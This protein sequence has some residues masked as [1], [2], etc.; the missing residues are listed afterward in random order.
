[1]DTYLAS[2]LGWKKERGAGRLKQ[3]ALFTINTKPR[4]THLANQYTFDQIRSHFEQLT[5][6]VR[7]A[8][9][10]RDSKLKDEFVGDGI[11]V[12]KVLG[13]SN[14]AFIIGHAGVVAGSSKMPWTPKGLNG[15]HQTLPMSLRY[16]MHGVRQV[17][18]EL[19]LE[20]GDYL[21][22]GNLLVGSGQSGG[23]YALG[24]GTA[25]VSNTSGTGIV[26]GKR[27]DI[28]KV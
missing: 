25:K 21:T 16:Y 12:N 28:G 18:E 9:E 23:S 20:Q 14:P 27:R 6:I 24:L 10:W 13:L 17:F 8:P 11:D 4:F 22:P 19:G 26:T 15:K 1:M 3:Q 2:K 7:E 5:P